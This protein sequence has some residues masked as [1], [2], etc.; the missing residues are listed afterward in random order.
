MKRLSREELVAVANT[1]HKSYCL[2]LSLAIVIG[3]YAFVNFLL[4]ECDADIEQR[5]NGTGNGVT[6]LWYAVSAVELEIVKILLSHGADV[7]IVCNGTTPLVATCLY[8]NSDLV[9]CLVENGADIH[10]RDD[11]GRTCLMASVGKSMEVVLYVL[12]QDALIN[13]MDNCGKT[14]LHYAIQERYTDTVHFLI[15]ND[16]DTSLL[17]TKCTNCFR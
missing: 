5:T 2:L 9:H 15:E 4:E 11:K 8:E 16:A 6:P 12:E 10:H 1:K 14:V 3:Q 17:T 7:N 13:A